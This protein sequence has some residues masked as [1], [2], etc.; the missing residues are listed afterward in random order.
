[1]TRNHKAL[2]RPRLDVR[3]QGQ[4]KGQSSAQAK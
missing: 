3:A 4:G 1:M 2:L